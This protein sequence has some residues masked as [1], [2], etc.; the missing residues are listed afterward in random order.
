MKLRIYTIIACVFLMGACKAT[1]DVEGLD[2]LSSVSPEFNFL[3]KTDQK[4]TKVNEPYSFSLYISQLDFSNKN[5]IYRFIPDISNTN[6]YFVVEN[7]TSKV[8]QK[9]DWIEIKYSNF[10]NNELK[11]GFIP[12]ETLTSNT[13]ITASISVN[14]IDTQNK[15][16]IVQNRSFLITP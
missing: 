10:V 9:K 13:A 5:T 8:F 11:M 2:G 7:G 16:S 6:G 12:T 1:L 14:C 15:K 3:I 4:S